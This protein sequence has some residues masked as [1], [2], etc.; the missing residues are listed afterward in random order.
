MPRL[1]MSPMPSVYSNRNRCCM[2]TSCTTQIITLSQTYFFL[3]TKETITVYHTCGCPKAASACCSIHWV[4]LPLCMSIILISCWFTYI[5]HNAGLDVQMKVTTYIIRWNVSRPKVKQQ[6]IKEASCHVYGTLLLAA[7]KES[8]L[9]ITICH[10]CRC[11][12]YLELDHKIMSSFYLLMKQLIHQ[13]LYMKIMSSFYLLMKQLIHQQLYK[14][15]LEIELC[16]MNM[17]WAPNFG[18]WR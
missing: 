16:V 8:L 10:I 11:T 2:R 9:L 6:K 14:W 12:W 4:H 3:W 7:Y 17:L 13:Q 1:L 15:W 5:D 18:Q